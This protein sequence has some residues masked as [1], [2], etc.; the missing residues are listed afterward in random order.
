MRQMIK[1]FFGRTNHPVITLLLLVFVVVLLYWDSSNISK[2]ISY[3]L[4]NRSVQPPALP[5]A[6]P[7]TGTP[8]DYCVVNKD[9]GLS[10][11]ANAGT[12]V[13]ASPVPFNTPV[14]ETLETVSAT[15]LAEQSAQSAEATTLPSPTENTTS[16]L[17]FNPDVVN[18]DQFKADNFHV[19]FIGVGFDKE[20]NQEILENTIK[21][22]QLGF[23]G[24]RIDFAY[25]KNPLTIKLS[26]VAQMADFDNI[27]D[28]ITLT[29]KI[30]SVHPTDGI[31]L[32]LNTD[33]YIGDTG[34]NSSGTDYAF[35]SGNDPYV[36]FSTTHEI[37]HQ[38]GLGDGYNQ[39]LADQIPNSEL[40]YADSM[41]DFLARSLD[42]L[43][44]IPPL[45]EAG[46][47]N[48]KKI[49]TFYE[50]SNNIMGNYNP[51]GPSSWGDSVF[52]PLQI[53]IMNDHVKQLKGGN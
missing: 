7:L 35:V 19:I 12:P 31:I 10:Y 36:I 33:E 52:T 40:F 32:L 2:I 17:T 49:Y 50:S 34:I 41:P 23:S 4:N 30:K 39:Y 46:T 27:I 53:Q 25:V 6:I 15:T 37:G 45:Y 1:K 51:Q 47:C 9:T 5:T 11:Q 48:S 28:F 14:P 3:D 20:T 26:H 21:E 29:A 38:L 18:V 22:V 44:Y 13:A 8:F 24:I 42:E 16:I 43:G